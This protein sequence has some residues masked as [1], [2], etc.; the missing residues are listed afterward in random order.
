MPPFIPNT[1]LSEEENI[2]GDVALS[3]PAKDQHE[4]RCLNALK[5]APILPS[6]TEPNMRSMAFQIVLDLTRRRLAN[7]HASPLGQLISDAPSLPRKDNRF[8]QELPSIRG[9]LRGERD[10]SQECFFPPLGE[11]PGEAALPLP[12]LVAMPGA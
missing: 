5:M 9:S 12:V 8:D 6:Q 1:S 4:A 2:L 3:P 10:I 11:V 7:I